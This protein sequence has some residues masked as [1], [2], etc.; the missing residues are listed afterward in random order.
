MLDGGLGLA[1]ETDLLVAADVMIRAPRRH[2]IVA[3]IKLKTAA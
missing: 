2:Q 3:G 1:A